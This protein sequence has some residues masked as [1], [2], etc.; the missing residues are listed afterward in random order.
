M[1]SID[2]NVLPHWSRQDSQALNRRTDEMRLWVLGHFLMPILPLFFHR[3]PDRG[4]MPY[5][6]LCFA[7]E[8]STGGGSE[9]SF[10]PVLNSC[11]LHSCPTAHSDFTLRRVLGPSINPVLKMSAKAPTEQG[12]KD[13]HTHTHKHTHTHTKTHTHT[14][15]THTH[16]E[17]HTH[18]LTHTRTS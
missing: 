18:T 15:N 6:L 9:I 11:A 5:I 12:H 17:T 7:V 2:Y 8:A 13:T 1:L 16:T 14:Q 3:V 4:S 10:A